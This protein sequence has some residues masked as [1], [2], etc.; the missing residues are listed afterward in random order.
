MSYYNCFEI[1]FI[2]PTGYLFICI[3]YVVFQEKSFWQSQM[4]IL[5]KSAVDLSA[6]PGGKPCRYGTACTRPGCR[7]KH[8][9]QRGK[10]P[11]VFIHN[12][13]SPAAMS[14]EVWRSNW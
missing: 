2:K 13:S 9:D 12:R 11:S 8:P 5:V 10:E 1:I 3:C 14:A 6:S 7:F 4:D